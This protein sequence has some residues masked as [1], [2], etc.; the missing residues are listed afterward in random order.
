MHI[1]LAAHQGCEGLLVQVVEHSLKD[2]ERLNLVDYQRVFLFI[3]CILHAL[4]QV[5]EFAQV[6]LPQFVDGDE[7]D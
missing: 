6:F 1:N 5:V 7:E 3:R 4:T 2:M